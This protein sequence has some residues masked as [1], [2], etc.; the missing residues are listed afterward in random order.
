MTTAKGPEWAGIL[1][2]IMG[3]IFMALG[4]ALQKYSLNQEDKKPPHERKT[5]CLQPV[6]VIGIVLYSSAGGL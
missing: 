3:T 5:R 2:Y 6:W 1:I 4:A